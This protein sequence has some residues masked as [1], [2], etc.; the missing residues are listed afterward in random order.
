M[1]LP[2]MSAGWVSW[3]E[4]GEGPDASGHPA[5]PLFTGDCRR[6]YPGDA[7]GRSWAWVWPRET[8]GVG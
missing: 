2:V 4:Q 8:S 5:L 6:T 3:K 1:R 7:E